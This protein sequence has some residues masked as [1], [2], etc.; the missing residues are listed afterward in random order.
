MP[1]RASAILVA[2]LAAASACGAGGASGRPTGH[3][4][5]GG[6]GHLDGPLVPV[7]A[8]ATPSPDGAGDAAVRLSCAGATDG[9]SACVQFDPT[10]SDPASVCAAQGFGPVV[11]SPCA[12]D[13]LAGGCH[14]VDGNS[15]YIV[16]S[17]APQ[18]VAGEMFHC[19]QLGQSYVSATLDV[20]SD[21]GPPP[22]TGLN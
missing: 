9:G 12:R 13:G 3:G 8:G 1:R 18:T 14:V 19:E 17:Y 15:G 2:A 11:T 21:A 10:A 22:I 4:G 7:D 5:A 6:A 16:W 20:P